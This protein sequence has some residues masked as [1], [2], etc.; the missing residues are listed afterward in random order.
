MSESLAVETDGRG[1]KM[2]RTL[3]FLKSIASF[4]PGA[5]DAHDSTP[6][7][8]S[9]VASMLSRAP[10]DS[11]MLRRASTVPPLATVA[12][13][14]TRTRQVTRSREQVKRTRDL[15]PLPAILSPDAANVV[16]MRR[17][18]SAPL[19][20]SPAG[21]GATVSGVKSHTLTFTRSLPAARSASFQ[22]C[23]HAGQGHWHGGC[24]CEHPKSPVLSGRGAWQV[25]TFQLCLSLCGRS[26]P[27]ACPA[28]R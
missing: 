19:F 23:C 11:G 8:S 12:G 22:A 10:A 27:D 7:S 15:L 4:M 21:D 20:A 13:M 24:N 16:T 5:K 3:Q 18:D 14:G 6:A 28:Q 17:S 25:C 1:K 26:D 2:G 9:S